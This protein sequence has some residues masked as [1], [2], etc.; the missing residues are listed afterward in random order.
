MKQL[1]QRGLLG[2]GGG[3]VVVGTFKGDVDFGGGPLTSAGDEDVFLAVLDGANPTEE[4]RR[5]V[6]G[7]NLQ[8]L[9]DRRRA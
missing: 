3:V 9:L 8:R 2:V 6:L 7:G 4:E 5:L 1:T